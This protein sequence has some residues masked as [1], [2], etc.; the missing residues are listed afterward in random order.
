[1]YFQF[2]IFNLLF[3]LLIGQIWFNFF[4]TV[5]VM[6]CME[7]SLKIDNFVNHNRYNGKIFIYYCL[8]RG[9]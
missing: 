4:L 2:W 8:K 3:V 1:M 5:A 9:F 7:I 6:E